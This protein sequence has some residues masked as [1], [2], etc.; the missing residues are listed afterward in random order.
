MPLLDALRVVVNLDN[1]DPELPD[2]LDPGRIES[3]LLS[4]LGG[5]DATDLRGLARGL[6]AADDTGASSSQL[7]RGAVLDGARLNGVDGVGVGKARRLARL[8]ASAAEVEESGGT[9]EEVLWA[10]WSGTEWGLRLR[11]LTDRGGHAAR[12]AHRDLDAVCALFEP[13]ARAEE[14]TRRSS[15]GFLHEPARPADPGRHPRRQRRTR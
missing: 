10:L 15:G 8:L 1:D 2:F 6:R 11:G 7:V 9:V 13:A 12:L 5:L 3:L 14:R 4:P